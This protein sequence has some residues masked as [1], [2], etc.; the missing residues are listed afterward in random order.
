MLRTN[1]CKIFEKLAKKEKDCHGMTHDP[2]QRHRRSA[3]T[4]CWCAT[5]EASKHRARSGSSWPSWQSRSRIRL[6]KA[7]FFCLHKKI[8]KSGPHTAWARRI[9]GWAF[10]R[11]FWSCLR[12]LFCF[13]AQSQVRRQ[14]GCEE[15][16]QGSLFGQLRGPREPAHRCDRG[17]PG[18]TGASVLGDRS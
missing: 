7:F 5:A 14:T 9:C 11:G 13:V 3:R 17:P 6:F 8:L 15:E 10:L 1:A 16:A 2:S 4:C 18:S 12:V